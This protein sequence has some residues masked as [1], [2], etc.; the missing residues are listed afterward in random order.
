MTTQEILELDKQY[1]L[2]VYKRYPIALEKG[3]GVEVWDYDGNKYIDVLAGIAVNSLGHSHPDMVKVIKEQADKLIHCSNFY[4]TEPQVL[5]SK[6]LVELSGL[7]R[8]FFANSGAEAVEGCIKLARRYGNNNERG[9]DIITM[10][11]CF[12]GRTMA[13]IAAGKEALQK[14][15]DPIPGG[16][17]KAQFNNIDS[18][19]EQIDENTCAVIVEP[20]QGEGGIVAA[21][22][23]YLQEVRRLCNENDMLLVFDEIQCGAGRT[24]NFFAFEESG[25]KPDII[26]MAKGMGGGIPIGAV[27]ASQ[28]VADQLGYGDHGTTFGGNPF[29]AA[30]A[31][32]VV[33]ILSNPEFLNN[34][35]IL[36]K[37]FEEKICN[38]SKGVDC[39][40]DIRI[41][42]LMIGVELK[43]SITARNVVED[44]MQKGVLANATS[45]NT[46]RIV[47]PLIIKKEEVDEVMAVLENSLKE[48]T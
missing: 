9:G 12:H 29:A 46:I 36:G 2:Q 47:P 44:M 42:G 37:Y 32:K 48:L 4:A 19:K 33:E 30:V 23:E 39:I 13:T 40:K 41:K 21:Q 11:G 3:K 24:G 5:L 22:N 45:N 7:N 18:L 6:Q 38:I 17:K 28:K 15:F 8:A 16:F 1:Y 20:V 31:N 25:V 10:E 27:I 14:G 43:E 34:V 26:A 35:K